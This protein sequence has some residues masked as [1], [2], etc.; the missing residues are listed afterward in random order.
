MASSYDSMLKDLKDSDSQQFDKL[1]N[2]IGVSDRT[3]TPTPKST[4][5]F[6]SAARGLVNG[7]SMGLAD[8]VLD[9]LN[10]IYSGIPSGDSLRSYEQADQQQHP[11]ASGA[12]NVLGG[13]LDTL[14]PV[15]GE[16]KLASLLGQGALSGIG[17]SNTLTD[18][19]KTWGD[20]ALAGGEGAATSAILGKAINAMGKGIV[21][22]QTLGRFVDIGNPMEMNDNSVIG[23]VLRNG[24]GS[25]PTG[26]NLANR[27]ADSRLQQFNQQVQGFNPTNPDGSA[28]SYIA[29]IIKN[30]DGNVPTDALRAADGR[31]NTLNNLDAESMNLPKEHFQD[32]ARDI[33]DSP[34][35]QYLTNNA[36]SVNNVVNRA[37]DITNEVDTPVNA[38]KGIL[39]AL[40]GSSVGHPVLGLLGAA[41]QSGLAKNTVNGTVGRYA[42]SAVRGALEGSNAP[43]EVSQTITKVTPGVIGGTNALVINRENQTRPALSN[44]D[45]HTTLSNMGFTNEELSKLK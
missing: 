5:A 4:T 15:L 17:N 25:S 41:L 23:N 7:A 9:G 8:E 1:M 20:T 14:V 35:Y 45:L 43:N 29:D 31:M 37:K 12:G 18:K 36:E 16:A 26:R 39:S 44:D 2:Q 34:F 13:V 38:D 32:I 6:G 28:D 10:K 11:L 19:T 21:N 24:L 3:P 33:K 22:K 30:Y 40:L 27:Y 42:Q